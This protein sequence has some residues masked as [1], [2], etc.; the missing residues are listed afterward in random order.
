MSQRPNN[1]P[2]GQPNPPPSRQGP[3]LFHIIL[4]F[5][6]ITFGLNLIFTNMVNRGESQQ[7]Q[8][9]QFM[10]LVEAGLVDQGQL[11][12]TQIQ[13]MLRSDADISAAQAILFPDGDVPSA[14][15]MDRYARTSVYVTGRVEHPELADWLNQHNVSFYT[16]VVYDSPL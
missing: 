4:V 8:Y 16:P 5:F 9:S 1:R 7:I 10:Q 12:D 11:D 15:W 3:N 13:L 14:E 6:L 2:G